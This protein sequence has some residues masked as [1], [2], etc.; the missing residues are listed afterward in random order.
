[1][2]PALRAA[3]TTAARIGPATER[4]AGALFRLEAGEFFELVEAG[5]DLRAGQGS[6]TVHAE[7]FAAEAAHHRS[8]GDATTDLLKRVVVLDVQ[9][10]AGH[11]SEE[12]AG[13]GI[14]RAGRIEDVVQ[15][16]AGHNEVALGA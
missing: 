13:K 7:L 6:K 16:V 10:E 1:M 15:Q 2:A 12:P 4:T 14:A 8:V 5:I 9:V 11:V 3:S